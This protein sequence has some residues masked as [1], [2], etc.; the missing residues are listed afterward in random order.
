MESREDFPSPLL[1]LLA[2]ELVEIITLDLI[3][4]LPVFGRLVFAF[5]SASLQQQRPLPKPLLQVV[6]DIR[7]SGSD[8]TVNG[9]AYAYPDESTWRTDYDALVDLPGSFFSPFVYLEILE[10][11]RCN[12]WSAKD[13]AALPSSL[14]VPGL[15]LLDWPC[16]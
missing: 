10:Y 12:N 13:F 9:R 8:I 16:L 6:K 4:D 3:L 2:K 7:C 14:F 15:H 11:P 5:R 1:N